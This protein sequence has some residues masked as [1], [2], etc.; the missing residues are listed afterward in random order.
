VDGLV[1]LELGDVDFDELRE[2]LRETADV[3][4]LGDD[5]ERAAVG[6]DAMGFA[7]GAHRDGGGHRGVRVDLHD[8][9]MEE[10]LGDRVTLELL[11]EGEHLLA[12]DIEVDEG[13][14]VALGAH[15]VA[16]GLLL[17]GDALVAGLA[18]DDGGDGAIDAE[19]AGGAAAME[20]AAGDVK[21]ELL[22]VGIRSFGAQ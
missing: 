2:I 14:G 19:A 15:E 17:D 3:D 18:V 22:H 4:G 6:L 8:V 20:R 7:D 13:G 10:L 21:G 1:D 12:V 16:E 5:G 11:D 9:D